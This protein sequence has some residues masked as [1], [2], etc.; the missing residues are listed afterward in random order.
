MF[1]DLYDVC[2]SIGL[3]VGIRCYEKAHKNYP[4]VL[5]IAVFT[6]DH[7]QICEWKQGE[8]DDPSLDTLAEY[9]INDLRDRGF[10]DTAANS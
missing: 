10:L 1:N 3:Y 7:T 9:V 5:G 8:P 4:A 2:D 6:E